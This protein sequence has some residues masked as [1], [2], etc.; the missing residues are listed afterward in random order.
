MAAQELDAGLGFVSLEVTGRCNLTCAHCY[1]ESG[2]GGSH[3]T[4]AKM[5]WMR[6][7]DEAA[8]VGVE[9]VQLIGGEPMLHPDLAALVGH[10]RA[11]GMEVEVYTNLAYRMSETNWELLAQP[12]VRLA[13]SYYSADAG[14]HDAITGRRGSHRRTRANIEAALERRI[15]LRAG[16][17]DIEPGQ[18]AE[19]AVEDLRELGV[20]Q[21]DYDRLRQ[22]GRGVRDRAPGVDQLCG[23]CG[24]RRLAVSPNGEVWPCPM[25]RWMCLGDVGQSSLASIYSRSME[26]RR[27][28]QA[29][30][31]GPSRGEGRN[32][33]GGD[34]GCTAPLC[35]DP[36]FKQK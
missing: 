22:L 31:H 23:G 34:G 1:A 4:M 9:R 17:I 25:A 29:E 8:A 5:D 6:V 18:R 11:L 19:M 3:G 14:E 7:L 36:H 16:V 33:D 13:T 26:T 24:D 20:V 30:M 27:R 21:I 32:K 10:S 12:G 35:C 2:P 15:P 28:L